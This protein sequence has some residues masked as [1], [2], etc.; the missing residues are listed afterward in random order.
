MCQR[1]EPR[2]GLWQPLEA[3]LSEADCLQLVQR[4]AGCGHGEGTHCPSPGMGTLAGVPSQEGTLRLRE[5]GT[6]RGHAPGWWWNWLSLLR[7]GLINVHCVLDGELEAAWGDRVPTQTHTVTDAPCSCRCLGSQMTELRCP[8]GHG[9]RR[10]RGLPQKKRGASIH[11]LHKAATGR[12]NWGT[13]SSV[14]AQRGQ[15]QEERDRSK[16]PEGECACCHPPWHGTDIVL[17]PASRGN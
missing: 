16:Q 7:L 11:K 6:C 1:H 3:A 8:A 13:H 17:I 9:R 2:C 5:L 12:L 4:R 15:V 10:Y 14:H